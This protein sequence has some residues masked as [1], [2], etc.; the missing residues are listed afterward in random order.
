MLFLG[1]GASG[2]A[3]EKKIVTHVTKNVTQVMLLAWNYFSKL[4]FFQ[5]YWY[6]VV[7]RTFMKAN[8]VLSFW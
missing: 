2:F 1:Q 5:K 3:S 4:H 8:N 7:R 6:S